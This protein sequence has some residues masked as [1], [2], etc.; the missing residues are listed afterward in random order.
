MEHGRS[1]TKTSTLMNGKADV[2]ASVLSQKVQFADDG[3]VI[4]GILLRDTGR[5]AVKNVV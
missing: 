1:G 5:V 2:R 3:S 4:P